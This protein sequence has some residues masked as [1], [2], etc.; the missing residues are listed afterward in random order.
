MEKTKTTKQE[1][2]QPDTS[3]S[4]VSVKSENGEV[5]NK[6]EKELKKSTVSLNTPREGPITN[7]TASVEEKKKLNGKQKFSGK[8]T[9][10]NSMG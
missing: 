7:G 8:S 5:T 3:R 2:K 9:L 4:Q 10:V 1:I 6:S